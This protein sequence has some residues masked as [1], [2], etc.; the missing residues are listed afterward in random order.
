M[1]KLPEKLCLCS[2]LARSASPPG[3]ECAGRF[4]WR[5]QITLDIPGPSAPTALPP[6]QIAWSHPNPSGK[7]LEFPIPAAQ[8]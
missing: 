7:S 5:W 6:G 2:L 3:Q 1:S 4:A 8:S